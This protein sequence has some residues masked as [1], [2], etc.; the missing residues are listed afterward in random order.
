MKSME[1]E[2]KQ[3]RKEENRDGKPEQTMA[4]HLRECEEEGLDLDELME[5]A[6][7]EKME[8]DKSCGLG[9]YLSG[10]AGLGTGTNQDGSI[11]NGE[12]EP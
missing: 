10:M 9:C 8:P 11:Q 3:L 4:R 5:V 2:K 12:A 7:G 6:G 1:Q